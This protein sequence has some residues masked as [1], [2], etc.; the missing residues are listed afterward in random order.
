LFAGV[1]LKGVSINSDGDLNQA[2]YQKRSKGIIGDPALP[3]SAAPAA[4][5][6]FGETVGAYAR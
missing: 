4:L 2:I 1:S 5:R 6:K 3:P